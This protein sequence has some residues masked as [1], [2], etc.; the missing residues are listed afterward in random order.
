MLPGHMCDARLWSLV[1]SPLEDA[2]HQIVHADLTCGSSMAEIADS[3]LASAPPLFV[4]V[5][6]SMG[7]IVAFEILRQ[8]PHRVSALVLC[9]T[10]PAAESRERASMRCEQQR[11]VRDGA[12]AHV[13]RN[14][15]KPAYLAAENNARHDLLDQVFAMAMDLGSEAFLRQS[16]ALLHRAD[17]WSVLPTIACP[18]LLLC[19]AE[20]IVCTPAL[21]RQMADSIPSSQLHLVEGAGHLPP[22][23]QPSLFA[24]HLIEWLPTAASERQS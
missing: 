12:L 21:H 2:G 19:G 20:D 4:A 15:L 14:D 24:D 18:T 7:G 3:V 5:G 8:Q 13:V 17:S 22:L 9:D 16:E 11:L 1:A 10:N 6:L 23:E